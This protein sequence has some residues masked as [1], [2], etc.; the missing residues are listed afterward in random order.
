MWSHTKWAVH[1]EKMG[2]LE[3]SDSIYKVEGLYY[4]A[5]TKTL[6]SCA[7]TALDA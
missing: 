5:K 1:K 6:I 7:V 2:R 4:V 3:I